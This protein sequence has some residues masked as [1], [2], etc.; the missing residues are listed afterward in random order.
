MVSNFNCRWSALDRHGDGLNGVTI[1]ATHT[2]M[3]L[4]EKIF[5]WEYGNLPIVQYRIDVANDKDGWFRLRCS[6]L[7]LSISWV[8]CATSFIP[9]FL[10]PDDYL[11]LFN[12]HSFFKN[13]NRTWSLKIPL[14][15]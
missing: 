2:G 12:S 11:K 9:V 1:L 8:V 10:L 7:W 14:R 4:D 6:K 5:V 15:P 3:Q 13:E